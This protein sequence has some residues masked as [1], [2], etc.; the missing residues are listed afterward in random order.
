MHII[1]AGNKEVEPLPDLAKSDPFNLWPSTFT[2]K[3][4]SESG[5]LNTRTVFSLIGEY[6]RQKY[7]SRHYNE[8]VPLYNSARKQH[9]SSRIDSLVET[10]SKT[11]KEV[12]VVREELVEKRKSAQFWRAISILISILSLA[13]GVVSFL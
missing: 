3:L 2:E 1:I 8:Y 9:R 10:T 13:L 6:I 4:L 5:C 7:Q 12:E 11:E